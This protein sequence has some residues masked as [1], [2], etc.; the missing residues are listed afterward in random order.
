MKK[1]DL[2]RIFSEVKQQMTPKNNEELILQIA[3]GKNLNEEIDPYEIVILSLKY[4]MRY[5]EGF[6]HQVLEKALIDEPS[7]QAL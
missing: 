1:A 6:L 4:S 2:E 7:E 5:A 3:N